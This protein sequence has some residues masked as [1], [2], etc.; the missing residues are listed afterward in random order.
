[1]AL[2]D[3]DRNLLDRC[4]AGQPGAWEDFVDRFM[5]LVIHVINHT[6]QCRSIHLS[7][8]DREDLAAEVFLTI[9]DNQLAV[10][11]HF[12][13]ES[14]LATYLT[15]I[16]R[17]V[18]VRKLVGGHSVTPLPDMVREASENDQFEQRISDREQVEQLMTRL[19]G[20]EAQVVRMYHLEGLSYQDISRSV[21]M[22][23]NSVGP[24]LSRARAKMR[25]RAETPG[26]P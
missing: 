25:H 23:V 3:L 13:Q 16:A 15:V 22:P 4:L 26:N 6:A 8:A 10:L 2:S 7:A 5:G 12:R 17:R 20:N 9:I 18:V 19:E 11:R 24:L 1:M 14:S 21:G